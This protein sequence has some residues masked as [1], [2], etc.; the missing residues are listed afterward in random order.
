MINVKIEINGKHLDEGHVMTT[1]AALDAFIL[2]LEDNGLGDDETGKAFVKGY[3][4]KAN[5]IREFMRGI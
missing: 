4:K 2:E 5:E 3:I 1:I